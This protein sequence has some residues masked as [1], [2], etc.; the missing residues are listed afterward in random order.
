MPI[1]AGERVGV[2]ADDAFFISVYG[3]A[4]VTSTDVANGY[5]DRGEGY[6]TARPNVA[7]GFNVEMEP[8]AD[9]D[10]Y[11]DETQD[12]SP[13][14]P[15][16]QGDC[17]PPVMPSSPPPLSGGRELVRARPPAGT[18]ARAAARRRS[19]SAPSARALG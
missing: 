11:G 12:C 17:P 18:R 5:V 3:P 16:K 10:G 6:G 19:S 2:M 7:W 4:G 14:D 15:A 8:D 1:K 13:G 9:G